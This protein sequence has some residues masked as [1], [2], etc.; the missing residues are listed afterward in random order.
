MSSTMLDIKSTVIH[1]TSCG[2]C[3]HETYNLLIE[4]YVNQRGIQVLIPNYKHYK[5]I[6]RQEAL[7][8]TR[9]PTVGWGSLG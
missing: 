5:E 4:T 7:K 8:E 3:P 6:K 9:V 1:K 2:H